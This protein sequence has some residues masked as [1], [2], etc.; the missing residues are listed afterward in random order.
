MFDRKEMPDELNQQHNGLSFFES[1][2]LVDPYTNDVYNIVDGKI[3]RLPGKCY[4]IWG[5]SEPC[6]N[7]TSR[8]ALSEGKKIVKLEYAMD[9]VT[10]INCLPTVFDAEQYVLE[11]AED[12]S[13]SFMVNLPVDQDNSDIGELIQRFNNLL[14]RDTF[15]GLFNKNYLSQR[16]AQLIRK[17]EPFCVALIDIDQFKKVNDTYGHIAGDEVIKV[18]AAK[19]HKMMEDP[20][21]CGVRFGGDEFF[22]LF[23]NKSLM[24]ANTLCKALYERIAG[25]TFGQPETPFSIRISYGTGEYRNGDTA[26]SLIQRIDARMYDMKRNG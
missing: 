18:I 24:Q 14:I 2:R 3:V 9:R 15:T 21:V 16:L 7:C 11:L 8:R 13:E 20:D 12:V 25:Y 4:E 6:G 1:Y 17:A 5:R 19:I 22:L 26:I 23:K 10:L